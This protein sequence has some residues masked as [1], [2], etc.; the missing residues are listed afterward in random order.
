[1]VDPFFQKQQ[2]A[3]IPNQIPAQPPVAS[4][5]SV[6]PK[7]TEIQ[8]LVQQQQTLQTQY[9]QYIA[10]F[11]N[12]QI[13]AQQKEEVQKYLQQLSLQYQQ[14]TAQLQQM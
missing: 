13:T 7:Q 6:D 12:P 8:T 5:V 11:Q 2:A 1:M 9:D 10:V 3:P 14:I 4:A